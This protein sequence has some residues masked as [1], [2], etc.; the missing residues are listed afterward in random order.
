MSISPFDEYAD[1]YDVWYDGEGKIL[2][3][4]EIKCVKKLLNGCEGKALEV[5]VGTGRFAILSKNIVG[6]DISFQPLKIAKKRE[7]PVI[8]AN[9]EALPFK[10]EIFSCVMMIVTICFLKNPLKALKETYRVLKKDGKFIIGA[11]FRDSLWGK[12]YE[13]K[14]T[15]G[16]PFYSVAKFYD[17]QEFKKIT[18]ES[19][20]KI[21]KIFGTLKYSTPE[22]HQIEDAFE[23][24]NDT[25]I[26]NFGFLC[27]ELVK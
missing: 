18:Y 4:N 5:G 23:L 14:K 20:F 22:Y 27:I 25:Q 16:H 2:Y 3:E 15:Q 11:V 17:F 10:S 19:G 13:E 7:I 1:K 12:F 24:N 9:A 26:S 8:Q 21:K 6:V